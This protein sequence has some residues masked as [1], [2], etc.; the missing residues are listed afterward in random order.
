[1]DSSAPIVGI[2]MGSKSDWPTLQETA[3]TLQALQI[4]FEAH[5]ASA[6][7]T[8]D[9]VLAFCAGAEA[10]GLKV[11]IAAAGGAAHLAGVCASQTL[12]P[13]LGVP[14]RGWALDGMDALL[15]TVQMPAGIPVGTLAIGKAGAVNA[16]LLAAAILALS[17]PA[18]RARLAAYRKA[19]TEK[20]LADDELAY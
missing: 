7:R 6:H 20:A 1:M 2:L 5:V 4:P 11:I 9:K 8:P 3:R 17:D 12:L 18:L 19:Q 15:A 13:V 10:R 16:A 14:M